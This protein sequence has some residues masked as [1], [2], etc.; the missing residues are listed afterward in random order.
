MFFN[1]F[2]CFQAIGA[3]RVAALSGVWV[4]VPLLDLALVS[5]SCWINLGA[6]YIHRAATGLALNPAP[7]QPPRCVYFWSM[8]MNRQT[9]RRG[10]MSVSTRMLPFPCFHCRKSSMKCCLGGKWAGNDFHRL[11]SSNTH[12]ISVYCTVH[13]S[14]WVPPCLNFRAMLS[15]RAVSAG[16]SSVRVTP[17]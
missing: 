6:W 3:E 15:H 9:D 13:S 4:R 8:A 12:T 17:V 16:Q 10:G 11:C 7:F 5:R 1:V 2:F 14:A